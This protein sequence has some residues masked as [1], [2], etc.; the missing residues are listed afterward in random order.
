MLRTLGIPARVAAGFT[1]GRYDSNAGRWLVADRNAHTWVEVWFRG[2]GWL[3]FDPTPGRGQLGG[4]YTAS[5]LRFDLAAFRRAAGAAGQRVS[6]L[7]RGESGGPDQTRRAPSA[8]AGATGRGGGDGGGIGLVALVAL[9]ALGAALLLAVAKVGR[10]T[11]RFATRDPR[12]IATACRRDLAGFVADQ[13]LEV[14]ESAT[15][16]EVS[17]LVSERFGVDPDPLMS[18]LTVARYGPPELAEPAAGRARHELRR[19]RRALRS[20][21]TLGRRARGLL[22]VRSLTA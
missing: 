11:V 6:D 15:N 21:L 9:L 10:R 17:A 14:P 3:A 20:H 5:S 16:A 4:S 2:Y 22:S 1:S 12:G 8:S 18:A 7:L 13:G 19:L